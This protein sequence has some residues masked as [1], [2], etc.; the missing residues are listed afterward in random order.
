MQKYV[1]VIHE[2]LHYDI[3]LLFPIKNVYN[4]N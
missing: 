1:E 2:F 3:H 4:S